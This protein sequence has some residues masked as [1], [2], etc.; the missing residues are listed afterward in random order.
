MVVPRRDTDL[1]AS[2]SATIIRSGFSRSTTPAMISAV[3]MPVI[4]S[5]PGESA[6]T[7]R[8]PPRFSGGVMEW[9]CLVTSTFSATSGPTASGVAF[10]FPKPH[11]R[12]VKLG[13]LR[14]SAPL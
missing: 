7:D 6:A 14:K 12:V 8:R 5:T 4:P 1:A 2:A 11:T 13:A 10:Q 9:I 3:S